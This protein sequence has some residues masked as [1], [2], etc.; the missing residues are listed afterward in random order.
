MALEGNRRSDAD[1]EKK[2]RNVNV[3]ALYFRHAEKASGIAGSGSEISSSLISPRGRMQSESLGAHLAKLSVP[4][5]HGTKIRSSL[6]PR[7]RETADAMVGAYRT[8]AD[9]ERFRARPRIELSSDT[10]PKD[11]LALYIKK[12]EAEKNKIMAK[13]GIDPK[14]FSE[15]T[16]KEQAEIAEPSE[17][18]VAEEWLNDPE[19]EIARLFPLE[20]AAAQLAVLVR[21]DARSAT[22]LKS[23][24]SVDLFNNTHRTM[25]EP[26][27]MR[28]M[29]FKDGG[30]PQKLADIGGLLGLNDGFELRTKTDQEGVP[31]TKLIMYRVKNRELDLPEYEQTEYDVDMKELDRL[32]DF[33][34]DLK[35]QKADAERS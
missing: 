9:I 12:W 2:G 28:I 15:L 22:R 23:G 11:F 26:L 1:I 4:G 5:E 33:G 31:M 18:P 17:I 19:S 7:T 14:N 24:S 16:P 6:Q 29:R 10:Q 25:T 3:R 20:K 35:R 34:L 21:R 32:A 13:L 8:P 30:K 27:L